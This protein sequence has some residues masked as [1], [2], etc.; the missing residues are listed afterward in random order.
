VFFNTFEKF[1]LLTLKQKKKKKKK[2]L[3]HPLN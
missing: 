2:F 3:G 1:V